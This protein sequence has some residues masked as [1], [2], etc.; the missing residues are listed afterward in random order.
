MTR[1]FAIAVDIG[2]TFTDLIGYDSRERVFLHAKSLTTP[3][4]LVE[5]ILACVAKSGADLAAATE[6]VHGSTIAI[7]TVLEEKGARTGLVVTRGTRD[8]YSIGRGNRPD[9]YNLFFR[10]P[11]PFVPRSLT[12][13]VP[14]RIL[15]SGE[16]E[17][18]LDEDAVVA[19]CAALRDA[20]VDAVAVCFLHSYANPEH[21]R[22]AGAIV[23]SELPDAYVSLSHEI[24]REYRE[25]ERTSTTVVN[26][27]IGP[28]VSGYVD[29]L[30]GRLREQGFGGD[31]WIM[32]SSGGVMA[33]VTAARQPVATMESGPVGGIIAAAEVGRELGHGNVIAFDMGGTT[34]KASLI[35]DGTPTIADGYY[36]GGYAEGHPVL[37][38]VVDVVEVGTGGG[39]IAWI[40]EVGALKVGPR[41]AGAEPGPICYGRGGA[42]PTITD[43][44]VT[45]GRI[46]HTAF[47]GG[48]MSLDVEAAR[49]GIAERVAHP[50]GLEPLAAAHG[51]VEIAIAKMAFAVREVSVAK[52]YDPRDFVLL[53][54]GGAGPLHALAIARELHIPRVVV[55]RYPGHFSAVGM[56]L[57]DQ[58]HDLVQ[59]IYT[60]LDRLDLSRLHAIHRE[61]QSRLEDLIGGDR[62]R[63][64]AFLD[65]RYVGQ[66]FTL[67]VP[68][69]ADELARGEPKTIRRRFDEVHQRRYGHNAA[70]EGAEVVNLR[71]AGFG[72]R[73]KPRLTDTMRSNASAGPSDRTPVHFEPGTAPVDAPIYSRE[74]LAPGARVTGPALVEEYASTTVLFAGDV[75]TVA[76]NLSLVIDVQ[77]GKGD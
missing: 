41:S 23:R 4:D 27:Y 61:M 58:R 70:D 21:E 76:D 72:R 60:R 54:S 39:S 77:N 75:V 28:V 67:P 65:M 1:D 22:R 30:G 51:I 24:L 17:T 46:R 2:G 33:P 63:I 35:R 37:S 31:L 14:E 3:Q 34:A 49:D 32:R 26:S 7:N 47:M 50:L 68:V 42:D 11:R 16:V 62:L 40:D 8:V 52:G 18:P 55:P 53:A 20:H 38:P 73:E 10:R 64:E 43:A 19:A 36:I 66:D 69:D 25:Y 44:N 9:A 12:F 15:A 71:M 57:T 56:L 48:E 74:E 29:T 59:T 5:G 6:L 45:L 13:E